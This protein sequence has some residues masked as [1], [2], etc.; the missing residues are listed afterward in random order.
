V[1]RELLAV[2]SRIVAAWRLGTHALQ[3][4]CLQE[5]ALVLSRLEC[6]VETWWG[7][8]LNGLR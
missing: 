4:L 3:H 5:L 2:V 7:G 6:L 8:V 1:E